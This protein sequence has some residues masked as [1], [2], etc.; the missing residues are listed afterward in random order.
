MLKSLCP[1]RERAGQPTSLGGSFHVSGR[2]PFVR[3]LEEKDRGEAWPM[4][5]DV[6]PDIVVRLDL[7]DASKCTGHRDDGRREG[8]HAGGAEEL[9]KR[10]Q[11]FFVDQRRQP[12][13]RDL[14]EVAISGS[15]DALVDLADVLEQRDRKVK[16]LA[17]CHGCRDGR[18]GAAL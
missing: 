9:W 18:I 15:L 16:K 10:P 13:R 11:R 17:R 4:R 5:L 12:E 2:L 1:A 3:E 8:R 6:P 7:P 14:I